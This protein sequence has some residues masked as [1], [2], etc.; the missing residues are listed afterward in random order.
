VTGRLL[1]LLALSAG[2]FAISAVPALGVRPFVRAISFTTDV[3][4]VSAD[5]VKGALKSAEQDGAAAAVIVLDTP[6]GL[7][8]SMHDIVKTELATKIPVI[9]YVPSGA[10]A[11][12]AGVWIAQAADLLAMAP[13][14]NIGSSTPIDI[15]GQNIPSDERRK[16]VNDAAASLRALAL[17]HKRNVAWADAA[18]RK[19]S[20]L[21]AEEALK[22]HV[23]DVI[24]PSLPALLA[25]ID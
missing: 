15:S 20:N 12:S 14:S 6:G 11:A 22:R 13:V 7:S 21:T 18:V 1:R 4:P 3:N 19:A 2:I 24:A 9:V 10:R 5:Y 23:I 17:Y 16:V 8:S 25:K